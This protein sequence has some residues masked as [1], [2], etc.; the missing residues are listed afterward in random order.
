MKTN[1]C[2]P[3]G[4]FDCNPCFWISTICAGRSTTNPFIAGSECATF[5]LGRVTNCPRFRCFGDLGLLTC[6]EQNP[7]LNT[8]TSVSF[9][10]TSA[11]NSTNA[12]TNSPIITNTDTTGQS[13][14]T[15]HVISV[16]T[17]TTLKVNRIAV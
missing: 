3:A 14:P 17:D 2:V 16:A 13:S 7:L 11:Q 5:S 9:A 8:K 15:L 4:T 10:T 6:E 12:T 1:G